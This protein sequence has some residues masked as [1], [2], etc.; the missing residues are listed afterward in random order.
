MSDRAPAAWRA[1]AGAGH[2]GLGAV[3]VE[4]PVV[5]E[6]IVTGPLRGRLYDLFT[7]VYEGRSDVRVI[8][9]RRSC[10]PPSRAAVPMLRGAAWPSAA[11]GQPAWIFPPPD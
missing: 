2:K 3:T 10:R 11:A 6:L 4:E 7:Q 8:M 9:D 5:R 1:R